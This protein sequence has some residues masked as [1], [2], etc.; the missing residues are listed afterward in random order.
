MFFDEKPTE[1]VYCPG[2]KTN[3]TVYL[4]DSTNY[5]NIIALCDLADHEFDYTPVNH[6]GILAEARRGF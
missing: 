5:G 6:K 2:C 4:A 3:A 1:N